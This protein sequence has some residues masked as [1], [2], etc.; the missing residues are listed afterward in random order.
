M[1]Q[2][3]RFPKRVQLGSRSVVWRLSDL[4][5]WMT[6]RYKSRKSYDHWIMKGTYLGAFFMVKRAP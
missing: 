4:S 6:A 5:P 1:E 3:G 2:E